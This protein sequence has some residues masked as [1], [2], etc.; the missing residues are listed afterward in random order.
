MTSIGTN[1]E[2][3]ILVAMTSRS[4]MTSI[5]TNQEIGILVAI[6]AGEADLCVHVVR[7]AAGNRGNR[8]RVEELVVGVAG[9]ARGVRLSARRRRHDQEE[10]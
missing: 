7:E 8:I 6:V 10:Q 9:H 4:V 3:G 2:I 1:Q 5:G